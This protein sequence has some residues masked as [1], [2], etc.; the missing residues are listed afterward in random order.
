MS[1]QHG[2]L[3]LKFSEQTCFLSY[4]R[5]MQEDPNEHD[6]MEVSGW[7]DKEKFFSN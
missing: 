6:E 4:S 3:N 1:F 7:E 2:T 5:N